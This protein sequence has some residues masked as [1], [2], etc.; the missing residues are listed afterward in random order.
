MFYEEAKNTFKFKYLQAPIGTVLPLNRSRPTFTAWLC[1]ERCNTDA[2]N[3]AASI[4]TCR[5]DQAGRRRPTDKT[6]QF[7]FTS[8]N[9][10]G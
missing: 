10:A 8:R 5:T 3:Y 2:E 4:L 7:D 1:E 6:E 9:R